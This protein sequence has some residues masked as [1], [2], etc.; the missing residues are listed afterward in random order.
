MTD[1]RQ[2]HRAIEVNPYNYLYSQLE[3]IYQKPMV[4][5]ASFFGIGFCISMIACITRAGQWNIIKQ[6][7]LP[8]GLMSHAGWSVLVGGASGIV[9]SFLFSDRRGSQMHRLAKD[10]IRKGMMQRANHKPF[11]SFSDLKSRRSA[12]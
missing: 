9:Y 7:V 6:R 3:V 5:I 11:Y 12:K 8:T 1:L 4:G 10:E 2:A